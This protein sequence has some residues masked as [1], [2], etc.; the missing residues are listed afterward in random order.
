MSQ[1][2]PPLNY[3]PSLTGINQLTS[4]TLPPEVTQCLKNARYLHLATIARPLTSDDPSP[5]APHVSLMNYTFLPSY[6]WN[7][8]LPQPVILMTTNTQ[9]LKTQNLRHNPRVSLLVHDWSSHRP[10]TAAPATATSDNRSG[11]PPATAP[12][13]SLASLLL[14]LNT[15]ALSSFSTTISGEARFLDSGSEEERWC[16]EAHLANNT[17]EGQLSTEAGYFGSST[18]GAVQESSSGGG[19][20]G[21]YIEG[22]DVRVVLVPVRTG[23]I[24]DFK[25][26]VRDWQIIDADERERAND[27][28]R[29]RMEGLLNGVVSS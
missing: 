28:S 12:P 11:S 9:S 16:K 21:G 7:N 6:S 5:P 19:D 1:N 27:N 25:G 14:N 26:G 10:P 29:G 24:S 15:S 23:R 13:S 17:F 18:G 22:N 4:T 20:A 2:N 8:T 3:E